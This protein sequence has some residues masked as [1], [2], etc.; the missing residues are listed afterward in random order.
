MK[1]SGVPGATLFLALFA[2]LAGA[3]EGG[4]SNLFAGD[5]GTAVWTVVI[6]ALVVVVLGKFAWGPLLDGLQQ[7]EQFI[8]DSLD[9]AKDDREQAEANLREYTEQLQSAR[10]EASQIVDEG[11][12]DAE[13]VKARIE[14]ET[15]AEA[16]KMVE[17]AKREVELAKQ[18]AVA[19]LYKTSATLAT[20]IAS[21]I[22]QRELKP[23]DHDRLITSAIEEI[24]GLDRN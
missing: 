16:D 6:F 3:S 9:K 14:A 5:I 11:R 13:V 12:R 17:R 2:R 24:R 18:T 7:R 19:E 1:R 20:Q 8:R 15:Q 23:E 22:L 21:Q 10:A 4:E